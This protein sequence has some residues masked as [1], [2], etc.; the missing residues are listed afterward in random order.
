[1]E[2]LGD[3]GSIDA[4]ETHKDIWGQIRTL[5][6]KGWFVPSKDEWSAFGGELGITKENYKAKGLEK[7][8]YWSSSLSKGTYVY[9]N[10]HAYI[11]YFDNAEKTG[12]LGLDLINSANY[13]RLSIIL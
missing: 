13:I 10:G 2:N 7:C 8:S 4:C 11:T 12:Y 3:Y 6:N 1:M 5:V 9:P